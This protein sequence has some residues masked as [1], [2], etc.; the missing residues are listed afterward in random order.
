MRPA[1]KTQTNQKEPKIRAGLP[2]AGRQ[3]PENQGSPTPSG[4]LLAL[5]PNMRKCLVITLISVFFLSFFLTRVSFANNSADQ[6]DRCTSQDVRDPLVMGRAKIVTFPEGRSITV[7]GHHHGPRQIYDLM[8]II[9]SGRL[10]RMTNF[11]FNKLLSQIAEETRSKGLPNEK[12]ERTQLVDM[13]KSDYGLDM[14][15]IIRPQD[16]LDYKNASVAEHSIA[17]YRYTQQLLQGPHSKAEFI[18]IEANPK[19]MQFSISNGAITR[20]EILREYH[21]RRM[22]GGIEHSESDIEYILL[23]ATNGS[24]YHY[25]RDP[26]LNQRI[27]LVPIEI[28]KAN[29]LY[30]RNDG[31]SRIDN[32]IKKIMEMDKTYWDTKSEAQR[33]QF[34]ARPLN[35]SYAGLLIHINNSV[36]RMSLSSSE[37]NDLLIKLDQAAPPWIGSALP[38]FRSAVRDRFQ[39]NAARDKASARNLAI[40]RQS[41]VHFVGL[42]H[43]KHIVSNLEQLCRYELNSS[44]SAETE[45]QNQSTH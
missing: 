6:K 45:H 22:R 43:L 38:E 40:R 5:S 41:G 28:E 11:E 7:V 42:N 18:G 9:R 14:S 30:D 37:L 35:L 1:L 16:G 20:T 15:D 21:K 32:S 12:E 24:F 36:M 10:Y 29:A 23:A 2:T 13:M 26:N 25:L 44:H 39:A 27:P 31:L 33:N 8:D 17:D 19:G 3:S 4:L 34:K